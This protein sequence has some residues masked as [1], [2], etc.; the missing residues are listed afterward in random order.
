MKRVI[1]TVLLVVML[2]AVGVKAADA[3]VMDLGGR[4]IRIQMQWADITPIGPR[5]QYNWYEPDERLQA[6]IESVEKCLTAK[7][8][9]SIKATAVMPLNSCAERLGR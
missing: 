2:F 1:L 5:G 8:N 3:P 4:T 9:L 7:L 6:H